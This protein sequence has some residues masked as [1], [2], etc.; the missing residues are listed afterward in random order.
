LAMYL[1]GGMNALN[2]PELNDLCEEKKFPHMLTCTGWIA[3]YDSKGH[4]LPKRHSGNRISER[5]VNGVDLVN[6]AI[7][8]LVHPKAYIDEVR[9]YVHNRNPVNPPYS[10]SQICRAEERLGIGLKVASTTSNE[11]YR[12][13]NLQ[14]RNA[15]WGTAY[16][17]GVNDQDTSCMIDID[18]AGF[19]LESKDRRRKKNGITPTCRCE[20]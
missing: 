11:A 20:G 7:F 13:A 5:E 12:P 9:A 2:T 4:V 1:W 16:P 14:K 15:Y 8:R 17:A 10:R 18:K 19:K 3:L 6:L